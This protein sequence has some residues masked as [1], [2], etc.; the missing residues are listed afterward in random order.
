[1]KNKKLKSIRIGV[2][3]EFKPYLIEKNEKVYAKYVDGGWLDI[4]NDKL[5]FNAENYWWDNRSHYHY[6]IFNV[7]IQGSF[8]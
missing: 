4:D 2:R 7:L 8:T 3:F 5:L 6:G 1:M